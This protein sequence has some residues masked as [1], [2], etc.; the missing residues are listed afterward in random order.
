[1][2]KKSD[3]C[4][5]IPVYKGYLSDLE[6]ISLNQVKNILQEYSILLALPEGL[7]VFFEFDGEK[8]YFSKEYFAS[9][10]SY[11]KLLLSQEFYNRFLKF[12][13]V[14][15]YQLDAF[16]FEDRLLDFC[17]MGYDYIGAPWLCGIRFYLDRRHLVW[18]VGNGGLSLRN[19][20]RCKELIEKQQTFLLDYGSNEDFFFSISDSEA[21]RVAP[22]EVALQFAFEREVKRCFKLNNNCLPFGCHA[23][24]RYDLAFWKQYIEEFGYMIDASDLS[25]GNEDALNKEYYKLQER[26]AYFWGQTFC[27]EYILE[28]L[29][30]IYS[31]K[32]VWGAGKCGRFM[33]RILNDMKIEF[34]GYIDNNVQLVGGQIDGKSIISASDYIENKKDASV[35]ISVEKGKT[36]VGKQLNQAGFKYGYDYIYYTD[37]IEGLISYK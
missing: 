15:I 8:E 32:Y 19:T 20:C 30:G 25:G 22:I 13:Y 2:Y 3:V 35:I 18:H 34:D 16:V 33:G 28:K 17:N 9:T 21:F 31:S 11:N 4:I 6:Q 10:K 26:K 12:R 24:S 23:W 27:K 14:L 7:Q 36:D 5:V 1:M 37:I 29:S